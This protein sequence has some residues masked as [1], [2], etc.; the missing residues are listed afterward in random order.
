MVGQG[1]GRVAQ[2]RVAAAAR[3]GWRARVRIGGDPEAKAPWGRGSDLRE[4]IYQSIPPG[5]SL[6]PWISSQLPSM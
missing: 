2:E 6:S 3:A 5:E 4:M 1:R